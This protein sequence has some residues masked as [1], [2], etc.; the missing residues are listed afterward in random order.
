MRFESK[1]V[2]ISFWKLN[3]LNCDFASKDFDDGDLNWTCPY[4][5]V[6]INLG[7]TFQEEFLRL[8]FKNIKV[9][10]RELKDLHHAFVYNDHLPFAVLTLTLP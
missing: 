3:N 10:F 5:V 9:S 8:D 4:K 7:W 2:D 6:L 1:N